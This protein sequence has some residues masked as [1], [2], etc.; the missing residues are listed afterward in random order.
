[1]VVSLVTRP[2]APAIVARFFPPQGP[3]A[4]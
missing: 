2:P 3:Q 4:K 1:V